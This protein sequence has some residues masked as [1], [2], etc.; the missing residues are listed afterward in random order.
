MTDRATPRAIPA[1]GAHHPPPEAQVL[2][3]RLYHRV[4]ELAASRAAPVWLAAVAFAESSFFPIP[5]DVMLAPMVLARRDK[6]FV[7]AAI[8]T[9]ASVIGGMLGYAIGHFLTPVGVQILKAFG[10]SEGM[11]VYR[12]WYARFGLAFILIKGLTPI[13]YKLVTISAGLAGFSF[14][15][16]VLASTVTRAARFFIVAFVIRRFGPQVQETLEKR[17]YLVTGVVLAVLV[18]GFIAAKLLHL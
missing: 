7:Y 9:I 4:L 8:C 5:P 16:F 18:I 6:A 14:P 15:Q 12:Q 17:L 3:R 2:L 10:H 11:E 1:T 13:P